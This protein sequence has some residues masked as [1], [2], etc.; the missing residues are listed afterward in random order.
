MCKNQIMFHCSCTIT[1]MA[2][3]ETD[4]KL[5]ITRKDRNTYIEKAF[6]FTMSVISVP[7]P[8][9]R[10]H[11]PLAPACPIHWS[12]VITLTFVLLCLILQQVWGFVHFCASFSCA[13][14]TS[15]LFCSCSCSLSLHLFFVLMLYLIKKVFCFCIHLHLLP[16]QWEQ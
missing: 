9:S 5:T 3:T 6:R 16:W 10:L 4:R 13:Y 1:F 14:A 11:Y 15:L 8:V 7:N 2:S 12:H